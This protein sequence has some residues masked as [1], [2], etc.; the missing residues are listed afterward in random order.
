[1]QAETE[2]VEIEK[3]EGDDGSPP[4]AAVV[5]LATWIFHAEGVGSSKGDN[6][7]GNQRRRGETEK[8]V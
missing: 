8:K 2:K 3:R 6:A 1:L 4:R 7:T 5:A